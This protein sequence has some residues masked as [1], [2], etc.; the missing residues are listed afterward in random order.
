MDKDIF[1]DL[2]KNL[3]YIYPNVV[4]ELDKIKNG[5]NEISKGK[6]PLFVIQY[7]QCKGKIEILKFQIFFQNTI[8]KQQCNE[9]KIIFPI[10]TVNN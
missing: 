2:V 6:Y 5:L 1:D 9:C 7:T 8:T 3:K 10:E 4:E